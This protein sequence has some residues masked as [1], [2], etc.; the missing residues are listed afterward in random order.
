MIGEE[1]KE[2]RRKYGKPIFCP[3]CKNV[4]AHVSYYVFP[5]K[6]YVVECPCDKPGAQIGETA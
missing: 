6:R 4:S 3:K 5:E 1:E 2:Y